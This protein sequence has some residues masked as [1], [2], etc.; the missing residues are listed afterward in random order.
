MINDMTI[1]AF[2]LPLL[3]TVMPF[4]EALDI[5]IKLDA[6]PTGRVGELQATN[7]TGIPLTPKNQPNY[8][9]VNGIELKNSLLVKTAARPIAY[10]SK[11]RKSAPIAATVL[12][13]VSNKTHYF[14][15]EHK[16][17]NI[18]KGNTIAIPFH[19]NGAP[20]RFSRGRQNPWWT[21]EVTKD[22]YKKLITEHKV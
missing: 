15:I 22:E 17:Y 13:H 7:L 9:M 21:F 12:N 6:F 18:L 3:N 4:H 5:L 20:K 16:H 14:W 2:G 8:D 1:D 10:F 11:T 19:A